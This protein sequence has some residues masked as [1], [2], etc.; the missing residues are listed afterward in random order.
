MKYEIVSYA[1]TN[2][3]DGTNFKAIIPLGTFNQNNATPTYAQRTDRPPVYGTRVLNQGAFQIEVAILDGVNYESNLESV[4]ALFSPQRSSALQQL[5][6]VDENE[7]QWYVNCFPTGVVDYR[8]K[9]I[10]VNMSSPDLSLYSVEEF[11]ITDTITSNPHTIA[12][13]D[14]DSNIPIL[15]E[16]GFTQT[17]GGA[18]YSYRASKFIY[19]PYVNSYFSQFPNRY[20]PVMFSLDTT[21]LLKSSTAT[22]LVNKVGGITSE[23]TTIPYDTSGG[24]WAPSGMAYIENE[25]FYYGSISGGNFNGVIRGVCGTTK[26]SHNNDV[27]IKYSVLRADQGDIDVFVNGKRVNRWISGFNTA[28][29]KIWFNLNFSMTPTFMTCKDTIASIGDIAELNVTPLTAVT[30]IASIFPQGGYGL[31]DDECFKYT[32]YDLVN[33]KLTGVTRAQLGT[34]ASSHAS[35][36]RFEIVENKVEF[37][38]GGF[39]V[40]PLVVDDK[41]KPV[42]D[43]ETSTMTSWDFIDFGSPVES[44]RPLSWRSS[45]TSTNTNPTDPKSKSYTSSM[46][47]SPATFNSEDPYDVIGLL[48]TNYQ[49]NGTWTSDT[50]TLTWSLL[51]P[52]GAT[53]LLY[54]GNKATSQDGKGLNATLQYRNATQST[55]TWTTFGTISMT[56]V[57]ANTKTSFNVPSATIGSLLYPVEFQFIVSGTTGTVANSWRAYELTRFRVTLYSS[58]VPQIKT[59]V[60]SAPGIDFI[61]TITNMSNLESLT[62]KKPISGGDTVSVNTTRK[63]GYLNDMYSPSEITLNSRRS[64]WLTVSKNDSIKITIGNNALYDIQ[65]K[66]RDRKVLSL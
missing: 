54:S 49:K 63:K 6:L 28:T 12:L 35:T 4:Q 40:E 27:Q 39:E 66:Y 46:Q 23:D 11:V 13:T 14:I 55:I 64:E 31:I 33:G 34:I 53:G 9:I 1:G 41:Y 61:A 43:L 24:T 3:N 50:V 30:Y 62:L 60:T 10:N 58:A 7:K 44:N 45:I 8:F 17:Y 47:M 59:S 2:I 21:E 25:Q 48:G 37:C 20:W 38:Y 57:L 26:T 15:P 52:C 18:K 65:I 22:C 16:I 32:G 19:N 36:T 56:G 5:I 29:T 51:V 42:L